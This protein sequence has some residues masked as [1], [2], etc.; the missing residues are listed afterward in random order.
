MPVIWSDLTNGFVGG[1][2]RLVSATWEKARQLA[3]CILFL[4]DCEYLFPSHASRDFSILHGEATNAFLAEWDAT[5]SANQKVWVHAAATFPDIMDSRLRCRF[6]VTIELT[7]PD[8][9]ERRQ[10]LAN[11]LGAESLDPGLDVGE[12]CALLATGLAGQSQR[13]IGYL[14]RSA[15][16]RGVQRAQTYGTATTRILARDDLLAEMAE[17]QE[18]RRKWTSDRP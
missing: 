14:V 6:A 13:D 10:I 16:N 17:M 15:A 7:L 1:S 5:R 12:I 8:E 3:P 2:M 18:R 11:L 9:D 4:D